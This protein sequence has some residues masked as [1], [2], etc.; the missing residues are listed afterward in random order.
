MI[1]HLALTLKTPYHQSL[2]KRQ[3]VREERCDEC[4]R[5]NIG[6]FVTNRL[7]FSKIGCY[8]CVARSCSLGNYARKDI[9]YHEQ[10]PTGQASE[11]I[12]QPQAEPLTRAIKEHRTVHPLGTG[13]KGNNPKF[14]EEEVRYS[15]AALTS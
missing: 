8:S 13:P 5:R 4:V 1:L 10:L 7:N 11:E 3:M 12:L 9:D 15:I 14:M 6:C 2:D